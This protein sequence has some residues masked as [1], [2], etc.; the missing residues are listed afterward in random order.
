[1]QEIPE[2][3]DL[4]IKCIRHVRENNLTFCAAKE[5][6]EN[7]MAA[8]DFCAKK[9]AGGSY[10][11][12]GVAMG[13]SALV[14]AAMKPKQAPLYLYDV[15]DLLPPP[16]ERD[17]EKAQTIYDQFAKGQVSDPTSLNYINASADLLAFVRSNFSRMNIDPD[18]NNVSFIKGLFQ[19]TMR[20]D[21][22]VSF[23]HIDCDWHDSVICVLDRIKDAM[24]P[25]GL[26]VFDDY[27]SFEGCQRAVKKWLGA[28]SRYKIADRSWALI[29]QR[30]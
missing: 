2:N 28:D 18:A 9:V 17:G 10:I 13:G 21:A 14:I 7:L 15:Y 24:L 30:V 26:I 3:I 16:S 27:H 8:V 5:K 6:L 29:V 22:P 19:D 25:G 20:I 1:M 12:A 4:A 11:E 23:C